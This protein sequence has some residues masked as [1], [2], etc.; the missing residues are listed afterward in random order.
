MYCIA[1]GLSFRCEHLVKSRAEAVPGAKNCAKP[2]RD[3][4][5]GLAPL[6]RVLVGFLLRMSRSMYWRYIYAPTL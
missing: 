2:V 3:V 1:M 4:H 6:N 5:M